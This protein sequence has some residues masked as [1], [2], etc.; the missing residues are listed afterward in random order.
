MNWG[1]KEPFGNGD[2]GQMIL[3]GSGDSNHWTGVEGKWND[4]YSDAT[5]LD[6]AWPGHYGIAEIPLSYFSVSDLTITEGESGNIT[7]S[8]TGGSNTVQNLT[9]ALSLIH[10]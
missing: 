10:I 9:L 5:F 3:E 4:E 7:I 2:K 6:P 8:R 1:V